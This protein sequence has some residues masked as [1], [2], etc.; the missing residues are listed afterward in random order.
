[1]YEAYSRQA[2]PESK[3]RELLGTALCVFNANNAF[4]IE[5]ILKNDTDNS[6]TWYALVDCDSGKLKAPIFNTISNTNSDIAFKFDAIVDMR[7]RII[8]SFQITADE[9][10]TQMLAT[11]T[12]IKDGNHQFRITEEYLL[13]F[14]K[15]N[16]ELSLMLHAHRGY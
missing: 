15:A 1:M 12:K 9:Q 16:D 3:N 8:H 5:N 11:K 6:Y 14:I 10:G 7:N 2:L 13:N 4:I